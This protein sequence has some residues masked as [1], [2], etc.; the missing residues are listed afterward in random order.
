MIKHLK[1]SEFGLIIKQC[2]KQL[3]EWYSSD[4]FCRLGYSKFSSVGDVAVILN[5][6]P[7]PKIVSRLSSA[8]FSEL[9]TSQKPAAVSLI[10]RK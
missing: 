2:L 6:P 4:F 5:H 3:T 7:R 8:L 10:A 1:L 9:R